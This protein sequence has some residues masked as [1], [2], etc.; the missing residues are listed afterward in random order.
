[1]NTILEWVKRFFWLIGWTFWC[2]VNS[3]FESARDTL[4]WL[5][6]HTKSRSFQVVR[7][8]K[9]DGR[10]KLINTTVRIAGFSVFISMLFLI[11]KICSLIS[12]IK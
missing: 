11:Y 9:V 10:Q 1:M 6:I 4:F 5:S 12:K 8:A 2:L 7:Y 3:D